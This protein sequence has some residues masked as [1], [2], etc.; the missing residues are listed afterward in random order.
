MLY[1]II[2]LFA[3]AAV[4]LYFL[5]SDVYRGENTELLLYGV[6]PLALGLLVVLLGLEQIFRCIWNLR[7]KSRQDGV[8]GA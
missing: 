7:T 3:L 4:F 6:L 1:V 8:S 5:L 2:A